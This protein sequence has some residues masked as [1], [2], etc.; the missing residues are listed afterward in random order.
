MAGRLTLRTERLTEL[1]TE[2]L[3]RV[4]GAAPEPGTLKLDCL[5]TVHGCTTAITCPRPDPA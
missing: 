5:P 3:H 4:N 2:E 1:T